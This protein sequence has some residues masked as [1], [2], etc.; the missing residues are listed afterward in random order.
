[1]AWVYVLKDPRTDEVRY[2][3][4]TN[5]RPALRRTN[6]ISKARGGDTKGPGDW[7]RELLSLGMTP[8]LSTIEETCELGERERYWVA[9]YRTAG[10]SLTNKTAGGGKKY[11]PPVI[12]QTKPQVY[13]LTDPITLLVRYVGITQRTLK[14]RLVGHLNEAREGKRPLSNWI[15]SL[16]ELEL[17]PGIHLL[18]ETDDRSRE[19]YWI[20]YFR[21]TGRDL[22]NLTDGG[23]EFC[24]QAMNAAR[25][26]YF[27][28]QHRENIR[29]A[30]TGKKRTLET[31]RNISKANKGRQFSDLHRE[32]ISASQPRKLTD[33]RVRRMR[34]LFES[35]QMGVSRLSEAFGVSPA[36][37]SRIVHYQ[38][39]QNVR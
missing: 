10:C 33:E 12:R 29:K 23:A 9:Y 5:F 20:L 34:N 15:R 1:M 19:T 31:C 28:P 21:R 25:K 35:G 7:I 32:R 37:T 38:R 4:A 36:T 18:E 27:S 39:Y 3:G 16:N 2:V 24:Y 6:H 26:G 13:V 8:V 11:L 14:A 17:R 30:N 22:T